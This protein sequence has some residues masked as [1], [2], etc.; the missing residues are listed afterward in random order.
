MDNFVKQAFD[1]GVQQ[2]MVDFGLAKEANVADKARRFKDL[3]LRKDIPGLRQVSDQA[4]TNTIMATGSRDAREAALAALREEQ[5]KSLAAQAGTGLAL[6]GLGY[7]A[8][9]G[10][11][12][13]TLMERLQGLA[14]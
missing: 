4:R 13:P 8:Y 10:L 1:A 9:E 2:A 11:R 3:L 5:L 12:E 6:G 7:G 14:G